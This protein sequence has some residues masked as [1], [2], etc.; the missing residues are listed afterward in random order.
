MTMTTQAIATGKAEGRT[1]PKFWDFID[2]G[3]DT[4][5]STHTPSWGVTGED[6]DISAY[7]KIS[8]HT[9]SWGVTCVLL[10]YERPNRFLLT[11]PRGA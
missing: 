1:G 5:I 11:R 7:E 4:A 2:N 9:P 8:T 3:D 6:V 10:E